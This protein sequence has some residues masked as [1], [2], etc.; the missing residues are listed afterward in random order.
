V[1]ISLSV[2]STF[3]LVIFDYNI[4]SIELQDIKRDEKLILDTE[5]DFVIHEFVTVLNDLS[6]LKEDLSRSIDQI[7]I[8]E[9][10]KQWVAF[11][12]QKANYDQIRY[13]NEEGVEIIRIDKGKHFS[14]IVE[15][16]F[17]QDKS[18]RYYFKD[19]VN[20]ND[21]NIYISP[22]DLNVE[23]GLIE[24]PHLPMVRFSKSIKY[25]D[26]TNAG[27]L[28]INYR[29]RAILDEFKELANGTLGQVYLLN[30]EGYF[31]SSQA[32]EDEWGFMFDNGITFGSYYLDEWQQIKEGK[33]QFQTENGLFT[34]L[35]FDVGSELSPYNESGITTDN[36]WL[37]VSHID[38]IGS[39][40][41]VF[42]GNFVSFTIRTIF[43]R[44]VI[45]YLIAILA[46]I[47]AYLLKENSIAM[48]KVEYNANYDGA[49]GALNR[50]AGLERAELLV[51]EAFIHKKRLCLC[52]IDI[53]GLKIVNDTHGHEAGD[54]MILTVSN[55]IQKE[56]RSNDV[57][58]R[59]GGDEFIVLFN[60]VDLR[61]AELIWQRIVN[62]I[63]AVN[64][65]GELEFEI[66]VSHGIVKAEDEELEEVL[67]KADLKMY[68]EKKLKQNTRL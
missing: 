64:A 17:L 32:V 7:D 1:F 36:N 55:A 26:G 61:I 24:M 49:T 5:H 22:M 14:F 6:Y 56:I 37:L 13:L 8:E 27:V 10:E 58:T 48:E 52:F 51:K 4:L 50:R 11:S 12:T 44:R 20:L 2:V 23:N 33:S 31:M 15:Q 39:N 59:I 30:E 43:D 68:Q 19:A 41:S 53:D 46:L 16:E 18:S 54:E 9:M 29:A 66:S 60:D 38:S 62:N 40:S 35:N 57:F 21:S 25:P 28:I 3:L 42:F 47:F 65:E 45:Y 34:A 67:S 63:D